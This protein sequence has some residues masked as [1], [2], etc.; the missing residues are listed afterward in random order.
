MEFRARHILD[1]PS[2]RNTI[3]AMDRSM[4][5]SAMPQLAS[6]VL[7]K[8]NSVLIS[9]PFCIPYGDNIFSTCICLTNLRHDPLGQ[10]V[11]R[12]LFIGVSV[13]DNFPRISRSGA[14]RVGDFAWTEHAHVQGP[15]ISTQPD[16]SDTVAGLVSRG[17]ARSRSVRRP[18]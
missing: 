9:S 6:P 18:L 8:A 4:S 12:K 15:V 17:L 2:T 7:I 5:R 16:L 1:A 3:H 14:C 10:V 13:V 11:D